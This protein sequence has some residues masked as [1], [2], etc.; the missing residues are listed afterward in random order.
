MRNKKGVSSTVSTILIIVLIMVV[1]GVIGTAVFGFIR[2]GTNQFSTSKFTVRTGIASANIDFD[3][4]IATIR[5]AREL[6]M[7]NLIGLKF[8]FEDTKSSE[9]FDVEITGFDELEEKTFDLDLI[10][11]DSNLNLFDVGKV[12]VAPVILLE[13]GEIVIGTP[14][15]VISGLNNNLNLANETF[16]EENDTEI[17]AVNADCGIDYFVIGTKYCL[18]NNSYQYKKVFTCTLGFC[19][20]SLEDIFM[21]TCD[22][23]CYDGDC[24]EE[25][26]GCAPETVNV[27]CGV[28]GYIGIPACDVTAT[29]V[30]QDY[31]DYSC[32]NSSCDLVVIS[33]VLEYCNS[34]EVCFNAECFVPLECT[35]NADC[36]GGEICVEGECVTEFALNSGVISSIWPFSIGEYFD[37]PD[38]LDPENMSLVGKFIV[39][40][41]SLQQGCLSIYEHLMPNVTGAAP[42]V[43]LDE[44]ITNISSLDSF[45]IW[46]T[47][48]V[49]ELY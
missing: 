32:I 42:Y 13:S 29:R 40:P 45:Q 23:Q 15:E 21:E 35:T 38:L 20:N 25:I 12:S 1:L 24:I 8:I 28:D 30:I 4:G 14:S 41:G 11:E 46:E 19:D 6:G 44:P 2:Q 36:P 47:N 17:C 10:S 33:Q 7:G 31:K 39:F 43:R 9:V 22:F 37:S 27:D 34:S 18:E 26:M 3:T 5:V 16:E 48:Y 49:C